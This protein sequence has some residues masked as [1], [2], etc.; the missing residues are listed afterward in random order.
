M[1]T[2]EPAIAPVV[3]RSAAAA[4]HLRPVPTEHP[5]QASGERPGPHERADVA[6]VVVAAHEPDYVSCR[7]LVPL[8]QRSHR[9]FSPLCFGLIP[10]GPDGMAP[11]CP[12]CGG[13]AMP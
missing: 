7:N 6:A 4:R 3:G 1:S 8:R 11:T 9:R 12:V 2:P 13:P 10:V 5:G